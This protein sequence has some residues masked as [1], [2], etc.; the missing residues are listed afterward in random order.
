MIGII[1]TSG[2]AR[3]EALGHVSP[4]DFRQFHL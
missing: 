3:Y 1:L 4:L 2:V